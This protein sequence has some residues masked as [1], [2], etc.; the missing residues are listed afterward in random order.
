MKKKALEQHDVPQVSVPSLVAFESEHPFRTAN[1][2]C[3][4]SGANQQLPGL[5]SDCASTIMS[6]LKLVSTK[7]Y[8]NKVY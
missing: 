8:N 1:T 5:R 3:S 7:M 6:T 4:D 2:H